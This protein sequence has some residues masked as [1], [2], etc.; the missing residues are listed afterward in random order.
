METKTLHERVKEYL[1]LFQ[2]IR[3]RTGDDRAA[4]AILQE[5]NKDIRME[6]I[7]EERAN[8]FDVG[9]GWN[10]GDEPATDRQLSYLKNLGVQVNGNLTKKK[11]SAM[12]DEELEKATEED[13]SESRMKVPTASWH[14][15]NRK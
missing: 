4:V 12:I 7:R 14:G 11:A 9:H 1:E 10:G 5:V 6:Q 2:A 8:G 15:H 13:S 3:Q